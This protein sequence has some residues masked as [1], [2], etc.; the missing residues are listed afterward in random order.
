MIKIDWL[1]AIAYVLQHIEQNLTDKSLN[2]EI[3]SKELYISAPHLQRAFTILTGLSVSEYIRNRRL[4]ASA[5]ALRDGQSVLETALQYGYESP[6]AFT[7]AFKRFHGVNPS[8]VKSPLVSLIAYPPLQIKLTLKGETP[9]NYTLVE[10]Q[11]MTLIGTS[12]EVS[13]EHGENQIVIPKFW[14]QV[15]SDG[16]T[17]KIASLPNILQLTGA[18]IMEDQAATTFTYAVAGLF[19]GKVESTEFSAWSVK[20]H[21]WAI[22][23]SIGPMPGAIQEV[24][25]RIF[26]EWFPATGF[27]HAAGPEL[28]I[29]PPGD[30]T[31]PQYRCEIW[32]P[33]VKKS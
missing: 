22:F 1:K 27:E 6:E 3:L 11:E 10:K 18:C 26:S 29:Y 19:E 2:T 4:S 21:T 7:K 13:T 8:E 25:Q 9:M 31:S 20:P 23:E 24:W 14:N 33:V 28:E 15:N 16:R 17:A 30:V 32:I 12:I 5:L